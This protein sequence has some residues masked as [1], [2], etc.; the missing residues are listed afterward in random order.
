MFFLELKPASLIGIDEHLQLSLVVVDKFTGFKIKFES[1]NQHFLFIILGSKEVIF[2]SLN[3][4]DNNST[5]SI[6]NQSSFIH[7]QSNI[8]CVSNHVERKI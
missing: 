2:S 6:V 1:K 4:N 3:Y 8:L 7:V 5:L